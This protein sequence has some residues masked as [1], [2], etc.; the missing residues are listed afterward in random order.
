[1]ST[2]YYDILG[3]TRDA[4][5]DEIKKAYR[6]LALQHH[7]D[8]N[9]GDAEAERLFK[10]AAEAYDVLRDP[11]KR[12]RYDRYGEA[13]LGDT[14]A[15][16]FTNVEDIFSMFGDLFG[17]G[18]GGIFEGIFGGGRRRGGAQHG[19]DLRTEVEL[20]FEE[21][22]VGVDK[23]LEIRLM[24]ACGKCSGQGTKSGSGRETCSLCRGMGQVQ[25]Q[26]GFFAVRTTCPQCRG[27]GEQITDP[28]G[29]CRGEGRTE[30]R[31]TIEVKIPA[32]IQHGSR[33]RVRGAGNEGRRGGPRGDLYV[34]V[35]LAPHEFL[36][37]EEDH[38]LCEVPIS[39]SQA[40]LGTKVE[41][42]SLAGSVSVTV[43]PGTQSGEVLRLR[44]QGFP[45]LQG[46]G[47]GDQLVRVYV[48]VPHK[49]NAEQEELLRRLAELEEKQVDS[50][51]NSFFQ[52]LK[53]YFE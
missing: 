23:E 10:Q 33:M 21:A 8:K 43:P 1:M 9:P 53:K 24:R 16:G 17:G 50:R 19:E 30:K 6:R 29:A 20:T 14:G 37:R 11:Q 38:V 5:D 51:R 22:S 4:S 27:E 36:E 41:V 34:F 28:C 52:R 39:Y 2:D 18:G 15:G 40:V 25:Q 47:R 42:P 32:G 12:E 45:H 13:G 49:V 48:D 35:S 46:H 26:Q 3:V 44:G 31:E 7:P